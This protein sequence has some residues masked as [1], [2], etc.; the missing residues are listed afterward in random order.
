MQRH[1]QP[2]DIIARFEA[3]TLAS[4][5]FLFRQEYRRSGL[6]MMSILE[7]VLTFFASYKLAARP[8]YLSFSLYISLGR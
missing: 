7:W 5:L 1:V 6:G 2:N 8:N 4:M 3:A